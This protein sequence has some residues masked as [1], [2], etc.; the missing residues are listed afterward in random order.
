MEPQAGFGCNGP[1]IQVCWEQ[2]FSVY[3]FRDFAS[4]LLLLLYMLIR[5]SDV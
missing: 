3:F 2:D 1:K 4:P 5:G